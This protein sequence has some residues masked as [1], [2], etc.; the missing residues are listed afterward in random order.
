MF[1][2]RKSRTPATEGT[3]APAN[4]KAAASGWA[5]YKAPPNAVQRG[6]GLIFGRRGSQETMGSFLANTAKQSSV[7]IGLHLVLLFVLIQITIETGR[8]P[9]RVE[10]LTDLGQSPVE[11][12]LTE[13][14]PDL[15]DVAPLDAAVSLSPASA[16]SAISAP[17]TPGAA[18]SAA[19]AVVAVLN[20]R[21][22]DR[23]LQ[24]RSSKMDL[25]EN[26]DGLRGAVADM[27]GDG[28]G[29]GLDGSVDR[30]TLEI[31]RQLEKSKVLVVWLMD[32]TGSM[33]MKREQVVKR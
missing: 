27:S 26:I 23:P 8:P 10:V 30:I 1:W 4:R 7:S 17:M 19:G 3:T 33:R 9:Q 11:E 15:N 13:L 14:G 21:A 6:L 18:P 12:N 29:G 28:D 20:N 25:G 32:S 24:F 22:M 31:I 16:A 2:K 5:D